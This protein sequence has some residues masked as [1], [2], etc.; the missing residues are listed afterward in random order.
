MR[1]ALARKST[2]VRTY[3]PEHTGRVAA[4]AA[5]GWLALALLAVLTGT[6]AEL[7]HATRSALVLFV[8]GYAL[9]VIAV[10]AGLR[11]FVQRLGAWMLPAASLA[12]AAVGFVLLAGTKT[13]A[14]SLAGD[15]G[16]IVSL[17]LA[18]LALALTAATLADRRRL[19]SAPAR[20]PV[21]RP[22]VP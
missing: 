21:A 10:D 14:E 5:A 9:A 2:N 16:A 6:W 19:S 15:A 17:V 13:L 11:G 20:S 4:G 7:D 1:P 22:D 3:P 12:F 18:P 8:N